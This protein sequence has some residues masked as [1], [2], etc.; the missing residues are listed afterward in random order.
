MSLITQHGFC[1]GAKTNN[2]KTTD[3]ERFFVFGENYGSDASCFSLII[4]GGLR[5]IT[6]FYG[7]S[8]LFVMLIVLLFGVIPYT[9]DLHGFRLNPNH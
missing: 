7:V 8:L 5:S 4:S 9:A 6:P 2:T 3:L 1:Q